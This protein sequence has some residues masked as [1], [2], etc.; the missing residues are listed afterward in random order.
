M[1]SLCTAIASFA[2]ARANHGRW[3]VRIDDLD[4]FRIVSGATTTILKTLEACE[5][6]W[7]NSLLFQSQRFDAY[8]SALDT[9]K[10]Q[11]L[12]YA[13]TCSRKSLSQS[14]LVGPNGHIYP[15]FCRNKQIPRSKSHAL[16]IKT[17]DAIISFE[18]QLQ[19]TTTIR[20]FDE[21][22]DFIVKR[23]DQI[24]AYQLAATVDDNEQN[25]SEVFRGIDLLS[26][27][28]RQI[29]LQQLLKLST[30]G[31]CHVPILVDE[32]RVKLSKQT[33][34]KPVT[35]EE[36]PKLLFSVLTLLKHQPPKELAL[37]PPK[38]LLAWLIENWNPLRL[39][40][41]TT[42]QLQQSD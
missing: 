38:E 35:V 29:Y 2:Q 41:I 22:G 30:P 36:A 39:Q 25:I 11:G 5:L 31:Y 10:H 18:D 19:G 8:Q 9:L 40:K 14:S 27:T 16:R 17:D 4:T 28:P 1:G 21:D 15:G 34:A 13:C 32:C 37:A 26:S 12:V 33:G 6:I 7:D 3:L 20:L 24:F 42:M 23:Q